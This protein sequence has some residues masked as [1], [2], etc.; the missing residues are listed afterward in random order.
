MGWREIPRIEA[1]CQRAH[2]NR[3]VIFSNF[4]HSG[5]EELGQDFAAVLSRQLIVSSMPCK[6]D[7]YF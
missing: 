4:M 1:A 6:K 2:I 5:E 7:F 3:V